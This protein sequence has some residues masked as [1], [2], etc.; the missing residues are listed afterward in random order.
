MGGSCCV[1]GLVMYIE[2]KFVVC[3]IDVEWGWL[4]GI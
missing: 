4:V 3:W 1:S 2:R